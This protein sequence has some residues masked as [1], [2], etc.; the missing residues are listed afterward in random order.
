MKTT[1]NS[2]RP[3][4]QARAGNEAGTSRLPVLSFTTPPLL[5]H[6]PRMKETLALEILTL[7]LADKD[8]IY[9]VF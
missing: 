7:V 6:F 1:E 5:E 3:G 9:A 8:C 4:R 2:E